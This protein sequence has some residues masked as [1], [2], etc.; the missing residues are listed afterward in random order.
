MTPVRIHIT[1]LTTGITRTPEFEKKG[2]CT[3]A[4]NTGTKCGHLCW[5]CS[6]GALL[7]MHRSFKAA[8]ESPFGSGYAI[9]DPTTPERVTRDARRLRQ[10]GLIQL[11]TTV[12]A[13]APEAQHFGLGRRC[14]EAILAEP[15]WRVRILTKNAAV[16]NDF[17]LIGKHKDRVLVGLSLTAPPDKSAVI[18]AVEP[19][20]STILERMAAMKEAHRLGLRTYAMFCPLLPGIADSTGA[21]TELVEFAL[22]CGAEEVFAEPVNARGPGLRLTQEALAAAGFQKEAAAVGTIR[23]Q[24]AWSHY[25]RN[26]VAN[27]QEALRRVGALEKLRFLL[28]PGRL[29]E[30]DREWIREHPEGVRWLGND[31]EASSPAPHAATE[32]GPRS[33]PFQ[34]KRN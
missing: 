22:A 10:R 4:V 13:W 23:R 18:R 27:I 8:Q 24:E 25:V 17:D 15:D 14:L 28:Y 7:R 20:A 11:C 16:G 5:Y 6:T 9:V 1:S 2:L 30:S 26:L 29:S 34:R 31:N 3:H 32:C 21:I 12:D 19:N 33:A